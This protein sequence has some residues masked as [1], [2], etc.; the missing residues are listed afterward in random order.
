M[1][2][3]RQCGSWFVAGHND[4]KV[5]ARDPVCTNWHDVG[6]D[7]SETVR[8][9]PCMTR[10]IETWGPIYKISYDNLTIILR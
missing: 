10:E 5:I 3:R 1:G 9:R 2:T 8:Q 7:L 4:R 6:L